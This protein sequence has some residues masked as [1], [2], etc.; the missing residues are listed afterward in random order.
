MKKTT[1]NLWIDIG[2]F[3]LL[4]AVV[5]TGIILREFPVDVTGYTV[6]GEPR[7]EWADLHWVLSL[8]LMVIVSVHLLCHWG[9]TRMSV[10]RH[11]GVGPRALAFTVIVLAV[12]SMIAAPV[13]LTK[14]LPDRKEV[15]GTCADAGFPPEI[16]AFAEE[17]VDNRTSW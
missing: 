13:Y 10:E 17:A 1:R 3:I 15:I 6:L 16:V 9:W 12:I 5:S 8:A 7:K 11:L 4:I 2:M 14:D